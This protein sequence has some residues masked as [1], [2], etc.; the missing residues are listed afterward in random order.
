MTATVYKN[1]AKEELEFHFDPQKS[2]PDYA[3]WA[4]RGTT[5]PTSPYDSQIFF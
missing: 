3:R 1:Y 2:V 4:E 5:E